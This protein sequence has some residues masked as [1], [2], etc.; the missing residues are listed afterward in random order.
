MV[1]L[2]AQAIVAFF[3]VLL[4]VISLAGIASPPMLL[5]TV[6]R[7]VDR[8]RG[9]VFAVVVRVV[10]GVALL[11]A[12]AVS[13]WPVLFQ[14]LGWLSLAAAVAIPFIGRE[15]LSSLV[16]WIQGFHPV[17]VRVWLVVGLL[18]GAVLVLGAVG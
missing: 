3:G 2:G 10:L 15:R 13:R 4:V 17:V 6:G 11:L 14:V 7:V 16:D 8:R 12:A 5:R 9:L 18:F 1:V